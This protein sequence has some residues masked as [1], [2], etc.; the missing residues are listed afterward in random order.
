[1]IAFIVSEKIIRQTIIN[2]FRKLLFFHFLKLSYFSQ[3]VKFHVNPTTA[4]FVLGINFKIS[5]FLILLN[6]GHSLGAIIGFLAT[7]CGFLDHPHRSHQFQ[8]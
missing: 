2:N 3:I 8:F 1:M 4:V 7:F 5:T 6:S